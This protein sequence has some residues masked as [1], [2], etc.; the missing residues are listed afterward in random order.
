M[1]FCS[2]KSDSVLSIRNVGRKDNG[3]VV[4]VS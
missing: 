1:I 3:I 4:D 2:R